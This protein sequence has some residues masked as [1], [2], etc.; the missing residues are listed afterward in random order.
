M[1]TQ[2]HHNINTVGRLL[3]NERLKQGVE[4]ADIEKATRIRM[5]SLIAIEEE[6]WNDFPSRT[7]IQ[8]VIKR[9]GSYLGMDQERLMAYFRRDFE[10]HE[11]IHFKEKTIKNQFTPQ[12]LQFIKLAVAG[13]VFGF[14]VF[15]GFQI[16]TFL[17]PPEIRLISPLETEFKRIE[18][19]TVRGWAEDETVITI[20]GNEVYLDENNEFAADVPLIEANTKVT[21]I[22]TGA[23]GKQSS[24][25][26]VYKKIE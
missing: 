1:D 19:I 8:G 10:R 14:V 25:E 7:Y 12:G 17:R 16:Y 3:K 26:R 9:Y 11:N 13:V 23:N 21:I 18:K 4:L 6:N 20:N 22:A 15:F 2:S 24:I 5:H